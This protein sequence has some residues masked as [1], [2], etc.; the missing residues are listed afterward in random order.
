MAEA[1]IIG[2]V[3]FG[4]LGSVVGAALRRDGHRVMGFDP[5][6][7]ARERALK[8]QPQL[9]FWVVFDEAIFAQA[10]CLFTGTDKSEVLARFGTHLAY[11]RADT[12]DGLAAACG[13]DA[14]TLQRT[15]AQYNTAVAQ[16]K[17]LL[18]RTHL[19]APIAQ[20]PFYA[21]RHQGVTLRCWAGLEVDA[22]LRVVGRNGEPMKG[23]YAVGEI[24]GGAAM[25]GD[26]FA[27][28][29]SITPALTFGRLLGS[30][31]LN[32]QNA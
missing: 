23:L 1:E 20:G 26:S 11:Q 31:W 12:L 8:R 24:L 30:D 19:P 25:S 28:G 6:P 32:W 7:D 2:V 21:I 4:E 22:S 5:S 16:G 13:M 27:S 17:D 15:V 18:G 3:G 29:M 10:P 9:A 14:P